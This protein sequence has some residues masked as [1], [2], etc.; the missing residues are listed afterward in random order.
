MPSIAPAN[1]TPTAAPVNTNSAIPSTDVPATPMAPNL[2]MSLMLP[3]S[4]ADN[5]IA[6]HADTLGLPSVSA[7]TPIEA[8]GTSILSESATLQVVNADLQGKPGPTSKSFYPVTMKNGRNLCAYCW[9]KQ[10][11]PN[12]YSQDFKSYLDLLGKDCQEKY[13]TDTKK[14]IS[15]GIWTSS[16]V[17][18]I[19][20]FSSSTLHQHSSS[21]KQE[22]QV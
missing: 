2:T 7:A 12:G 14:L 11:A 15:D 1:M 5:A 9:L 19:G 20:K 21:I 13:E 17:K 8:H 6:P 3:M 10:V 22:G 18:V 4:S 16:T